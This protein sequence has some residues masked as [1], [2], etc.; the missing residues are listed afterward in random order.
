MLLHRGQFD[1][2]CGRGGTSLTL[3]LPLWNPEEDGAGTTP[4]PTLQ[5]APE[6]T[7]E[8]VMCR[9]YGL[10]IMDI[11]MPIMGG[12]SIAAHSCFSGES[13]PGSELHRGV[14]RQ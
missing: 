4:I 3:E 8:A 5:E 2:K 9:P 11:D 14:F 12:G 13:G 1:E 10:I 7:S 6:G